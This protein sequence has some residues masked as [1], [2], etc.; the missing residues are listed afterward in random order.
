MK[1]IGL[2]KRG[3]VVHLIEDLVPVGG[4]V[5]L[6]GERVL[7]GGFWSVLK[8]LWG[9]RIYTKYGYMVISS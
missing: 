9:L 7:F 4:L 3:P 6:K 8:D 2:F 1:A 5:F